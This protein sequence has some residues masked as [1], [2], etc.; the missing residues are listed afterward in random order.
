VRARRWCCRPPTAGNGQPRCYRLVGPACTCLARWESRPS[1][2]A[3]SRTTGRFGCPV[4]GWVACPSRGS[5]PWRQG[6]CVNGPAPGEAGQVAGAL[7]GLPPESDPTPT[8]RVRRSRRWPKATG[9]QGHDRPRFFS[10]DLR[11][12]P[13]GISWLR[14]GPLTSDFSSPSTLFDVSNPDCYQ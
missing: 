14:P 12:D 8:E 2:T 5:H 6:S 13:V 7:Q 11:R 3:W 10:V 1:G 9:H 4:A